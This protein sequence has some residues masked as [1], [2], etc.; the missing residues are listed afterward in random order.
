MRRKLDFYA[1]SLQIVV[2][3]ITCGISTNRT[4]ENHH[5]RGLLPYKKRCSVTTN[6]Q[7]IIE[8]RA[9]CHNKNQSVFF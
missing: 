8:L 5:N 7:I 6:N 4:F 1:A 3:V 9:Q 2:M